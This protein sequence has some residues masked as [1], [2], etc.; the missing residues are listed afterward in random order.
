M[1]D[2]QY[3]YCF[4]CIILINSSE[5][6]NLIY[7][8][9]IISLT[10]DFNVLYIISN[11]AINVYILDGNNMYVHMRSLGSTKVKLTNLNISYMY[12]LYNFTRKIGNHCT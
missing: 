6:L 9:E 8:F 4:T 10:V 11:Y 2:G 3:I 5:A 7:E 12:L 1:K